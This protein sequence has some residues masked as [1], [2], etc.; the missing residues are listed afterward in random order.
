MA[1]VTLL[2]AATFNTSSGTHTVVATPAV[3]DLIVIIAAN[4]G[5]TSNALPTD[6]NSGGAGTYKQVNTCVKA[7][8]ADT[9]KAFIRDNL[10]ASASSTT[11][12]HAVGTSSGGGLAVLK[13]TGMSRQGLNAIV[14]SAV[15]SNRSAGGTPTPVFGTAAQTA[16]AIIGAVFNATNPA[17]MT[18]RGTPAYTERVDAGYATPTTGLEVMSIDSGETGTN[19]AWGGTSASAFCSL[20]LEL[21]TSLSPSLLFKPNAAIHNNLLAR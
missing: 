18:P 9:M 13:V 4:T 21:N 2:G 3:G 7:T 20:A 1:S 11:F 17:T 19:I 16:N 6:N 5:N 8:S 15:Q 12:T 14:Q 10:I